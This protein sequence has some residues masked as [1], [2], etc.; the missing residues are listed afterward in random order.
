MTLVKM[1]GMTRVEDALDAA[2]LGASA[3]G[4]VF[5]RSSPRYIDPARARAIVDAL[6][7]LVTPVGVFVDQPL[8]DVERIAADA[9]LGAVQLHGHE[10]AD[11]CAR[12]R[13]PVIKAVGVDGD[14]DQAALDA[15]PAS[16]TV[17]L[18][19]ADPQRRGGTGRIV[20]WSVAARIAGRRRVMLAGGLR[21][22][23]VERAIEV[24]RPFAVDVS[25]GIEREPGVKDLAKMKTFMEA[26]ARANARV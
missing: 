8:D 13:R 20:D 21:P 19:A 14:V 5:W 25:S 4:F 12:I 1:C 24:V 15:L 9:R 23:N 22:D 17:L 3:V 11:Y 26:V 18:D 6:P 7:P 16:V 10:P 2:A